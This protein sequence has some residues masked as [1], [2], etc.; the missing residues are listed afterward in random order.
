MLSYAEQANQLFSET[1]T[2][3]QSIKE[4]IQRVLG[5][6]L[7]KQILIAPGDSNPDSDER[8]RLYN[9]S[10]EVIGAFWDESK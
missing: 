5:Y 8:V 1:S 4:N 6:L 10:K 3:H 7:S 9:K 2:L